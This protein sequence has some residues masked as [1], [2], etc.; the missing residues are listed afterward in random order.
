MNEKEHVKD[1]RGVKRRS[2]DENVFARPN[3]LRENAETAMSCRGPGPA[4]KKR[5]TSSRGEEEE[6]A[7]V[8]PCGKAVESRAH[9]VGECEIYKEIDECGME[10]FDE[11]DSSEK[12]IAIL[13]DRWWP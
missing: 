2:R 4:R 11:L 6:G 7:Q 3:G 8:C 13:T 9:V 10:K 12:A 5:S 1:L